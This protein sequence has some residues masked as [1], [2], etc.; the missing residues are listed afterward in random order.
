MNTE[1]TQK[2]IYDK[3]YVFPSL[4]GLNTN[5]EFLI[6]EK[7]NMQPLCSSEALLNTT[8]NN[9]GI[10]LRFPL[11]EEAYHNEISENN[12]QHITIDFDTETYVSGFKGTI[13]NCLV[14]T[15]LV[16]GSDTNHP[17]RGTD[18]EDEAMNA[19]ISNTTNLVH[20]CNFAS[21][22]VKLFQNDYLSTNFV[23]TYKTEDNPDRSESDQTKII[24]E[25]KSKRL[26]P[27]IYSYRLTPYIYELDSVS[28]QAQFISSDGETIGIAV[29][30]NLLDGINSQ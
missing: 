8:D 29:D 26:S 15:L 4:G 19:Y 21:E 23:L 10:K 3:G 25:D 2:S 30:T 22:R 17:T 9:L 28:L 7:E 5:S 13:Q 1:E 18:L 24:V 11:N 6:T 16:T 20:S 14:D 27:T 12:K